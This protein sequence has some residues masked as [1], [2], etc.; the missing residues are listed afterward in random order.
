M[1][2]SLGPKILRCW[3]Y[4]LCSV[5]PVSGDFLC[6]GVWVGGTISWL[7]CL[8]IIQWKNFSKIRK[9]ILTSKNSLKI[10]KRWKISLYFKM[11]HIHESS[12]STKYFTLLA[13]GSL[14]NGNCFLPAV[15]SAFNCSPVLIQCFCFN[16]HLMSSFKYFFVVIW[17]VSLLSSVL[18]R[19]GTSLALGWFMLQL[20]CLECLLHPVRGRDL[21]RRNCSDKTISPSTVF[22][23]YLRLPLS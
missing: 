12:F 7:S 19:K 16:L 3:L 2:S 17:M 18:L 1:Y 13:F 21:H 6:V 9:F 4:A 8:N 22:P 5:Q 11:I 23:H 20:T 14:I 10:V 15:S